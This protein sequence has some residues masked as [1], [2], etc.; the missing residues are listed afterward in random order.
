M[1]TD[2]LFDG[3]VGMDRAGFVA[4]LIV[5]LWFMRPLLRG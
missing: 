1:V 3:V 4:A 2:F 5:A